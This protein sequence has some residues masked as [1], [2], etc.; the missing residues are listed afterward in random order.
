[1][2]GSWFSVQTLY[3][4]HRSQGTFYMNECGVIIF[5]RRTECIYCMMIEVMATAAAAAAKGN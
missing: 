2:V 1:M 4:R 3:Y 5:G